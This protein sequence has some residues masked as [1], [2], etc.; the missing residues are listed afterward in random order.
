M[1]TFLNQRTAL[2]W[3]TSSCCLLF[4]FILYSFPTFGQHGAIRGSI[5]DSKTM[6][7]L[8]GATIV[9]EGTTRATIAD[10][11]GN[12]I[13]L[14][15]TTGVYR[16]TGSNLSY[17]SF[18]KEGVIVAAGDTTQMVITLR[19]LGVSLEEVQIVAR[20]NRE[21]ETTLLAEQRKSLLA[22]QSVGAG[23]LSRKGV[24]D[25]LT[26]VAK[27]SG[28]S[29]QEGVKNVFV[30]GL[31]DRYNVTLLNGMPI[32][33]EDP[34]YKNIALSF[35]GTDIIQSIGVH[36]VFSAE[37]SGDVGGAVINILSKELYNNS[38]FELEVSQ[39][40]NLQAN[41]N[42]FFRPG[43]TDFFG[44]A[45]T[46]QPAAGKFDFSN[47][48]DPSVVN[49]PIDQSYRIWGGKR[50][51]VGKN[52][53]SLFGVL[54]HSTDY[55]F[56]DE[57][58]R[59]ITTNGTI[60]Q[61]QKGR[62][63]SQKTNQLA[64]AN[65]NYKING[66]HTIAYN[67]MVLHATS[68]YVGE[69]SGMHSEK[70]QDGYNYM[71]Y[72]R[73]QQ[74]N[75]N[76]LFTHQLLTN[77]KLSEKWV[78]TVDASLNT[79]KGLEPDRR[80][81]YL[82]MKADSSYGLTGSNRQKRFFSALNAREYN[83]RLMIDYKPD[84][85]GGNHSKISFG[86]NL[87][88]ADNEFESTEYNF[89]A[90]PN[91]SFSLNHIALDEVYNISNFEKG[92][93]SLI[94]GFANKYNVETKIHAAFAESAY[95]ITEAL[96][97]KIGF[98]LDFVDM[99][100]VYDVPGRLDQNSIKKIYSL[101]SLNLRYDFDKKNALRLG[102]SK[103]YTLPQSKE[104]SP[105]QYVDI[106]FASEGN[107]KIKPSDNYN[108]DLKWDNYPSRSELLSIGVFYKQ[109]R[110]PIGRVD[111]GNSAG[112]LT[113]DN[114][115]DFA[116]VSG[117]E[118]EARKNV[119]GN[120]NESDSHS[121]RFSVGFSGSYIYTSV[122]LKLTNTPERKSRLEGASPF[123][124]NADITHYY[125]NNKRNLTSSLVFSYFSDRIFTNGTVGFRDIIEEGIG[126]LDFV[127]TFKFSR[128]LSLKLRACNLLN[129][130]YRL[131]RKPTGSNEKI[132]LNEFKKGTNLTI[133][134]SFN[135]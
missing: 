21:A 1:R 74:I 35:F 31:G 6:A 18:T 135:L 37:T 70:H 130:Y 42:T 111:K 9:I 5:T 79:I 4:L 41:K 102:A 60:Y 109:I 51:E 49:L 110:N 80:E 121:N 83:G 89:S 101:P 57:I 97:G 77:W 14:N 117:I 16:I 88:L 13:I 106:G 113:Y 91:Q 115:G 76:R 123:L 107:P 11:G 120:K 122:L 45:N 20:T 90:V 25:A 65:A 10:S 2:R 129:P 68:Q 66:L 54:T 93:F 63:Y 53:L 132:I 67:F 95:Q 32:P 75:D 82:S 38:Q 48:L 46:K 23:E 96:S 24:G 94:E 52:P 104:I 7:P 87:H 15:I 8:A 119:L 55:S 50:I 105:Y 62:R 112:L 71:G 72:L 30:R 128:S 69:Y 17:E 108:I 125:S 118:L 12:F 19:P 59:N 29:N 58:V 64:L 27:V 34:E 84:G 47:S 133:G 40:V 33:S 43:G 114:I 127:S 73:R 103:T 56:T 39:G 78:L 131:T 22:V 116:S 3:I 86:Y 124:A 99:K 134:A 36:K 44:F 126:T 98:R 92:M 61:D 28:I 100:V 26:A 85:A 81:N